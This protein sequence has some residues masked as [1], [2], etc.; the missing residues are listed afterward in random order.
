M[1]SRYEYPQVS[2]AVDVSNAAG[3]QDL[4]SDQ[5]DAVY[6]YVE[7]LNISVY[8]AATG[9]G[10][11]VRV[12]DSDGNTVWTSSADG[13]KDLVLDWGTEGLRLGPGVGLQA[14]VANAQGEQASAS[15]GV[16]GHLAFR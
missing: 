11:I 1:S 16:K 6:L 15:V 5:G 12:Q 10:G 13:V 2:A 8:R 3:S 14:I 7:K 9:G 4:V